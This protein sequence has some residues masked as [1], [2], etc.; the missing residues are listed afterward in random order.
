MTNLSKT[1]SNK[2]DDR[3]GKLEMR[4]TFG[5]AL[6]IDLAVDDVT[7]TIDDGEGY[8]FTL[9]IP[10]GSF[11]QEGEPENQMFKF[12]S[13]REDEPNSKAWFDLLRCEFRLDV[14]GIRNTNRMA[15]AT[16]AF[17]SGHDE[18]RIKRGRN[19]TICLSVGANIGQ[20]TVEATAKR[21]HLEYK[22][23]PRQE[24]CPH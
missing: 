17:R 9:T 18:K 19:L 12:E 3:G 14:K 15:A 16:T 24:C 13:P 23:K 5:P 21:N 22:K 7:Y 10:A 6:P 2:G 8:T 20:E 1:Y 11:E 4:G